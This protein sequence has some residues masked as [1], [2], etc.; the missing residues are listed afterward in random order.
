MIRLT[1]T[2]L[3]TFAMVS[4]A[5]AAPGDKAVAEMKGLE[6]QILGAVTLIETA[7]GVLVTG[8]LTQL[9]PGPHGFHLHAVGQCKPPFATAGG[10]FNPDGRKHG[11]HDGAGSHAGDLPNLHAASDGKAVVDALAP[12]LTLSGGAKS[13][14]DQDGTAIVVHAKADDYKTDPAGAS[15]D[16]IACGVVTKAR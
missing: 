15:G 16:R 11:F 1:S 14:L 4:A 2:L 10:H 3:C 13:L 12:G 7:Q 5:H 6:G 8:E 9:S